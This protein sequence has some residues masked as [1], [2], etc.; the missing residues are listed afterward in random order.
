MNQRRYK[1]MLSRDQP[2]WLPACLDDYVNEHN[3]VRVIDAWVESLQL[4]ELGFKQ[5]QV[6]SGVGQPAYHPKMLLKLYVYGYQHRIR[7]SRRL[8]AALWRNLELIWLCQK[9]TPCYKTIADFRKDNVEALK[10]AQREFVS[11]CQGLKLFGGQLV[12]ID[13]TYL[14]ADA[15]ASTIHTDR[16]LQRQLEQMQARIEEYYRQL[17]EFDADEA[18]AEELAEVSELKAKME[19]WLERQ[20]EQKELQ[21]KL[22]A[23]GDSQ[24]SE[25]DP[26]AR[27]LKKTG[28]RHPATT[29]RLSLMKNT[30]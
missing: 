11:L 27:L 9:A 7:S 5:S 28:R 30:N 13:G 22:E 14:K 29:Y 25:V 26:D 17:D 24:I 10:A 18:E 20:K 1:P 6:S 4:Q 12:A 19:Y 23:S 16:Q 15:N 3:P 21:A 8:E 2:A